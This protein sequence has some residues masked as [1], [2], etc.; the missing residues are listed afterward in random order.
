[1][2]P[3]AGAAL[4]SLVL[5]AAGRCVIQLAAHE[6]RCVLLPC[7][8]RKPTLQEM[9]LQ[10]IIIMAPAVYFGLRAIAANEGCILLQ[11]QPHNNP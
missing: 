8:I 1:L 7:N 5:S 11:C 6:Q 2:L 3:C 9:F 4:E 10:L